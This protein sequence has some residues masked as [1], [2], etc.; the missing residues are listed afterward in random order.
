MNEITLL[1]QDIHEICIQS[2]N[3]N[4]SNFKQISKNVTMFY[5]KNLAGIKN[6]Y[7]CIF[8]ATKL[9]LLQ[10]SC[11]VY[12][13]RKLILEIYLYLSLC[14]KPLKQPTYHHKIINKPKDQLIKQL[15]GYT[16][17]ED[18]ILNCV[19]S[20][21]KTDKEY[22]WNMIIKTTPY[23]EYVSAL[24]VL[25]NFHNNKNLLFNA[26]KTIVS[27]KYYVDTSD[28]QNIIFQCMMKINYLYHE[29]GLCNNNMEIY[30]QCID[31]MPI[32][33]N[34]ENNNNNHKTKNEDENLKKHI[35]IIIPNVK[36]K[37]YFEKSIH[38]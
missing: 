4:I 28:Y 27:K 35:D 26:Y 31:Y 7:P 13:S 14:N 29:K 6:M 19:H 5:I 36:E 1:N 20:L 37:V 21:Y 33:N 11:N 24:Y 23:K 22:M 16:P 2:T 25:F 15:E 18:I 32:V 12:I 8:I 34:N 17:N 38:I 3:I 10:N 9:R 30:N